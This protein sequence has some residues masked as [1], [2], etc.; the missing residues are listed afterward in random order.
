MNPV[1]LYDGVCALCNR[2]VQF[3]LKRDRHDRF[4]FAA[5]QSPFARAILERRGLNPDALD[6]FHIVFNYGESGE[7][8]LARH[9]AAIA[10]LQQL[11]GAWRIL[12]RVAQALPSTVGRWLYN[13]I[14]RNRYRMFG[15]YDVC[16]LPDPAIRNK[17]LDLS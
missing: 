1:I 17:F 6:T 16:P 11:G 7:Q 8:V 13:L 4:L 12:G 10:V 14:A 2:L 3:I 5:L 9:E 15:K